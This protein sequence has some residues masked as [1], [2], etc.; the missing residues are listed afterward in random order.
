MCIRDS[1]GG[2]GAAALYFAY[3]AGATLGAA[4]L[5]LRFETMGAA[6][7]MQ[8][9]L[10]LISSGLGVAACTLTL[11][12]L[13]RYDLDGELSSAVMAAVGRLSRFCACLLYTSRCV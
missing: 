1:G 3:G 2:V 7:I 12:A 9:A 13:R 6:T 10:S 5:I 8:I 11:A 4:V